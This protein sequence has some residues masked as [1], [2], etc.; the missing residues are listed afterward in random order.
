[1]SF[2]SNFEPALIPAIL[3]A[4]TIHEFGHGY[5]A[6][7]FNDPTAKNAGRLTLNPLPHMDFLGTL[8]FFF[9]GFG[10]AK[11]VPVNPQYLK[12]PKKD[13]IFISLAGPLINLI[14]AFA[15]SL[16]FIFV[17]VRILPNNQGTFNAFIYNFFIFTIKINIVLAWFNLIPLPPLDGYKILAGFLPDD[18]DHMMR[19]F[20]FYGPIIFI[21]IIFLS[22]M[23]GIPIISYYLNQVVP[24]TIKI[25]FLGQI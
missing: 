1:M 2:F 17:L 19:K 22:R 23:T 14:V 3:I 16:V 24:I 9:V 20:E 4:I 15:F 10:W 18:M 7:Y 13:L 12:N 11:P 5:V 25:M 21:S 8:M 6:Y